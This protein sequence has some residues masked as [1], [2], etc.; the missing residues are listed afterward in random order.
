MH[1]LRRRMLGTRQ[2]RAVLAA[3]AAFAVVLAVTAASGGFR[4]AA[5]TDLP[6]LPAGT[7]VDLGPVELTVLDHLVTDQVETSRLESAGAAAWLIVRARV[8]VTGDETLE[9]LPRVL[10]PPPGSTIT[11]EP[12]MQVLLRDGTSLPQTHP[13]LP[14]EVAFLWA[15]DDPA[16]VPERLEL[17][18]LG[19]TSYYSPIY[20]Q[21]M[22]A[23]PEPVA[24]TV[25]PAGGEIPA[26]LVEAEW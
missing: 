18:L 26:V 22:W 16:D 8:E 12:D 20:L 6:D 24:R 11:A 5:T 25:P 3:A 10:Q 17:T 19:S 14:E 23:S 13:G 7:P 2:G 1:A 4:T 15:V 21:D 9:V